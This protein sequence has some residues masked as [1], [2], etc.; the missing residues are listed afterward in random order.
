[1]STQQLLYLDDLR[2]GQRFTSG[3]HALDRSQIIAFA[4]QF[5]PQPFH[6]DEAAA[7]DTLWC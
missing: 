6:V 4:S 1:M 7:K 2:V 3:S 5:D